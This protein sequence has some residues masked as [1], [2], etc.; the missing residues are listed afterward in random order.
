MI[1]FFSHISRIAVTYFLK[2]SG[3]MFLLVKFPE[4]AGPKYT[5]VIGIVSGK[6]FGLLENWFIFT[7]RHSRSYFQASSLVNKARVIESFSSGVSGDTLF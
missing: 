2:S 7:I 1:P 6:C 3:L 5:A 4:Q